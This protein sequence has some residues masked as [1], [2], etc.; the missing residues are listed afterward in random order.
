MRVHTNDGE[1]QV[2]PWE[3]NLILGGD[4]VYW[5]KHFRRFRPYAHVSFANVLDFLEEIREDND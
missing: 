1:I 4:L 5:D 2:T 3:M